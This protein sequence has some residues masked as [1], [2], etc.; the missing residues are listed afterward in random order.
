MKS[1]RFARHNGI[2]ARDVDDE[3]FLVTRRT[4]EHL[5]PPAARVWRALELPRDRRELYATLRAVY[6]TASH[7]RL[8]A[9]LNLL[10]RALEKKQ[11]I[12]RL[13]P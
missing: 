11:L 12:R 1:Q 10:L 9:D 3:T 4:I 7:Q 8:N 13:K 6:P 2:V 5:N